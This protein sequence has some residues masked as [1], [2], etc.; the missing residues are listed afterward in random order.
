MK[1]IE[2]IH[3]FALHFFN[4]NKKSANSPL[5]YPSSETIPL[6]SNVD[7]VCANFKLRNMH[8]FKERFYI[9]K[10]LMFSD[11]RSVKHTKF[12]NNEKTQLIF[13]K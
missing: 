12:F 4:R 13:Y 3:S 2:V 5:T 9:K 10:T 6:Y 7:R 1:F 8:A 11:K